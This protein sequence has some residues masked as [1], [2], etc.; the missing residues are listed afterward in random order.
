MECW[1]VEGRGGKRD[2]TH[3]K[4]SPCYQTQRSIHHRLSSWL[5]KGAALQSSA[6]THNIL[7]HSSLYYSGLSRPCAHVHALILHVC[8]ATEG[9]G[10]LS[11]VKL[12]KRL[13][14]NLSQ[15]QFHQ[16][17]RLLSLSLNLNLSNCSALFLMNYLALLQN[18][19][20]FTPS[21]AAAKGEHR[22]EQNYTR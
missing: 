22:F 20:P 8:T 9:V 19:S 2:K 14:R 3:Y 6:G 4:I 5:M 12:L 7:T 15:S 13:P 21:W 10:L 18:K 16:W 11:T 1:A 17:R